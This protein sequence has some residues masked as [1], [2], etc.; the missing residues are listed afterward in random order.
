MGII[1]SYI[2]ILGKIA[3]SARKEHM[4]LRKKFHC[5]KHPELSYIT[6]NGDKDYQN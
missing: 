5:M 3:R 1:V 6:G 4:L 2:Y